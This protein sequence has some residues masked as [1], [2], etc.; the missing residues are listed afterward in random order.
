[1]VSLRGVDNDVAAFHKHRVSAAAILVY[2][3][4]LGGQSMANSGLALL[5][6]QTPFQKF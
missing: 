5:L 2:C 4:V 6:D 3:L 1:M